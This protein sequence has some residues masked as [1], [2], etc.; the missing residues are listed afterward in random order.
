MQNFIKRKLN[1]LKQNQKQIILFSLTY[2]IGIILGVFFLGDKSEG[3]ILYTNA[4]NYHSYVSSN[5]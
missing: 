2:L 1:V 5:E 4:N 3:S